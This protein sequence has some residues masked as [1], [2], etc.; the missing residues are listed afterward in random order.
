MLFVCVC[1][2]M[3]VF[4]VVVLFALNKH[5]HF[6]IC[7]RCH[8]IRCLPAVTPSLK[9][10]K[11]KA[12]PNDIKYDK[13]QIYDRIASKLLVESSTKKAIKQTN[14]RKRE[15][16]FRNVLAHITWFEHF[17]ASSLFWFACQ[18]SFSFLAFFLCEQGFFFYGK[19][20]I[21]IKDFQ[22]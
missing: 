6:M 20:F 8:I 21:S 2:C 7:F 17:G 4:L 5:T 22:I 13:T 16:C 11:I 3:C 14:E 1:L 19:A 9:S 15:Q 10:M 12:S 18:F